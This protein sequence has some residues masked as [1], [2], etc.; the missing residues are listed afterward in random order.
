MKKFFRFIFCL[1]FIC[2][3]SAYVY[4]YFLQNPDKV[5]KNNFF[6]LFREKISISQ[7]QKNPFY[8]Y[9]IN[10]KGISSDNIFISEATYNYITRKITINNI[11][12]ENTLLNKILSMSENLKYITFPIQ[13][14]EFTHFK[15]FFNNIQVKNVAGEILLKKKLNFKFN[16]FFDNVF[17]AIYG[18]LSEKGSVL[19]QADFKSSKI[20]E[21]SRILKLNLPINFNY[22]TASGSILLNGGINSIN[23]KKI[24][25]SFKNYKIEF[26]LT[27]NFDTS[28][29]TNGRLYIDNNHEIAFSG[30]ILNNNNYNL[31]FHADIP[32]SGNFDNI[33]FENV[34]FS[35]N[36]RR[37]PESQKITVT[38]N[39]E[40]VSLPD[41]S[42]LTNLAGYKLVSNVKINKI[43]IDN[44]TLENLNINTSY[45]DNKLNINK[46]NF[47]LDGGKFLLSLIHKN[48]LF[49]SAVEIKH[50]DISKL[51][52]I[53][54]TKPEL[55]GLLNVTFIGEGKD[56]KFTD[57]K[58]YFFIEDFYI[59][60][61]T[62]DN[63]TTELQSD[64]LVNLKIHSNDNSTGKLKFEMM[65]GFI[66]GEN[67]FLNFPKI[68]TTDKETYFNLYGKI[69]I[70]NFNNII[71]NGIFSNATFSKN[72]MLNINLENN[73]IQIVGKNE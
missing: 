66:K 70:N 57:A 64:N 13:K 72:I 14:I 38:L 42:Y 68:V 6:L 23:K 56:K 7:I 16:G 59:N 40:S 36:Y 24:V 65:K 45:A 60:G 41:Y 21:I 12:V 71:L 54:Y 2:I 35:L 18:S 20:K 17:L 8:P 46:L 62:P 10:F 67:E 11:I 26:I 50:V 73:L 32:V 33:T 63:L 9:I 15:T 48:E 49:Q 31:N 29:I 69:N 55:G 27:R 30:E 37:A 44:I 51:L 43:A 3:I 53:L 25:M 22:E 19:L 1:F 34:T 39:G 5:L 47:N 52:K 28:Q 61:I 4:L 58:G